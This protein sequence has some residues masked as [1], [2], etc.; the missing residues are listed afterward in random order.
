M[1]YTNFDTKNPN[2]EVD[3]DTVL[4]SD[5]V[6]TRRI[7][8]K[9]ESPVNFMDS[10]FSLIF[11]HHSPRKCSRIKPHQMLVYGWMH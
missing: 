2:S 6:G 1:D 9:E 4:N 11:R 5:S 10:L 7:K 3:F 8:V